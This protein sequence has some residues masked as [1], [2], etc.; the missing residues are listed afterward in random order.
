MPQD[1]KDVVNGTGPLAHE[2]ADKPH[3][4]VHDLIA[5]LTVATQRAEAAEAERDALICAIDDHCVTALETTF[6]RGGNAKQ[7]IHDLM[8]WSQEMGAYFEKRDRAER[9]ALRVVDDAMVERAARA[10]MNRVAEEDDLFAD[11]EEALRIHREYARI[12]LTAALAE[13]PTTGEGE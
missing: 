9:E 10:T 7:A 3:Q 12:A 4:L 8:F 1:Y 6:K 5:A 2:W 11:D 13:Q